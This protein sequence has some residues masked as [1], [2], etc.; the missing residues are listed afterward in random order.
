[1]L[2]H[3]GF[4]LLIAQRL[5]GPVDLFAYLRPLRPRLR[6]APRRG[7]GSDRLQRNFPLR[8]TLQ[9]I[10]AQV[11]GD[12]K[13]PASYPLRITASV[14]SAEAPDE[15][16]LHNIGRVVGT[17]R[18]P[19]RV[20][21]QHVLVSADENP[22][23]IPV[24]SQYRRHR[25]RVA[26]FFAWN[27]TLRPDPKDL[28]FVDKT[29]S[30]GLGSLDPILGSPTALL[31]DPEP[32]RWNLAEPWFRNYLARVNAGNHVTDE[33]HDSARRAAPDLVDLP[34]PAL[35]LD[36]DVLE[37]NLRIMQ[38]RA[39]ALGVRLRPHVKTHK[40][41]EI[42]ELQRAGGATG[43]TVSTLA[44]ARVFAEAGFD[45]IVWAFPLNP[46]RIA[47]A[48]ELSRHT[49]LGVTVDSE[50]AVDA[51]E[52]AGARFSVWLEIDCGYGRSGIPHD[53]ERAV[54]LAA[55]ISAAGTL[56]LRGCL[57][58]AGH[59]YAADSPASITALAEEERRAMVAVGRALRAA[60]IE[61]GTLSVGSTP[62]M[63]RVET[64]RG[65][66]EARPGNYALYDYSQMRLGSCTLRDCAV[67][68]LSTVVSASGGSSE[69]IADC[70]ALAL[71]KDLGPDD[72][73]H[74]GRLF[75]HV[76]GHE[77]GDHRVTSVSQEH[78]RLSGP[79]A[80]GEKIR[81]LPNHACL[82]VAH[83][84]HFDVVRGRRVVD[85]WRIRRT[86]D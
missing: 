7:Q 47:E 30:T 6:E 28:L 56:T 32:N 46:S 41:V 81:V 37:N 77:L 83:F 19:L 75:R 16:V 31:R 71:S 66:H 15:R 64:L 40:C 26:R 44:E 10:L 4:A 29:T 54:K 11:D 79:C 42:A 51:L 61:P 25:L 23:G 68:V 73:P 59:T 35:V 33:G 60:G 21:V 24:A 34:T 62:G 80:V 5:Q 86:R 50:T 14:E 55:R 52:A 58:H 82:T 3:E 84:D 69:A 78:G 67:T 1:M 36:L 22:V 74:Y 2:E 85:R 27:P 13:Q 43:F 20:S 53:S 76:A 70:G 45:D 17:T 12:A 72:P 9:L 48:A 57:T 49:A 8:S 38:A 18:H 65:V 63:S 39:D